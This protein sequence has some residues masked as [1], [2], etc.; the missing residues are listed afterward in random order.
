MSE[1][2]IEA[3]APEKELTDAEK[4]GFKKLPTDTDETVIK[5]TPKESLDIRQKA[6]GLQPKSV[7]KVVEKFTP[8]IIPGVMDKVDRKVFVDQ[9]KVAPYIDVRSVLNPTDNTE[10]KEAIMSLKGYK[11]ESP[12]APKGTYLPFVAKDYDGR[13]AEM[14]KGQA[15]HLIDSQDQ[16]EP[17][18]F[19]IGLAQYLKAPKDYEPLTVFGIPVAQKIQELTGFPLDEVGGKLVYIN[20]LNKKLK[21]LGVSTRSRYGIIKYRLQKEPGAF[22]SK[23]LE[24]AFNDYANARGYIRNGVR[25]VIEA[26]L[27]IAGEVFDAVNQEYDKTNLSPIGEGFEIEDP[28]GET[29]IE[30]SEGR[31]EL[32]EDFLPAQSSVIQDHFAALGIVVDLPTSQALASDFSNLPTR[33]FGVAGEMLIPASYLT[34]VEK[35][36]GKAEIANFRHFSVKEKRLNPKIT[37][38]DIL[39]KYQTMRS[40]QVAGFDLVSPVFELPFVGGVGKKINGYINAG[41]LASGMD[42]RQAGMAMR[43][44]NPAIL[45]NSKRI[46]QQKQDIISFKASRPDMS[47]QDTKKLELME[48]DLEKE[49]IDHRALVHREHIPKFIRDIAGQNK[50]MIIGA[51]AGGQLAENT[52]SDAKIF[53]LVGL[54]T[55]LVYGQ[56]RTFRGTM[57][58]FKQNIRMGRADG[59]TDRAKTFDLAEQMARNIN[60]FSPEFRDALLSR[61]RY[62]GD[63][64]QRLIRAGVSEDL[65][66]RS[67]SRITGLT[68]LQTLEEAERLNINTKDLRTFSNLQN[69]QELSKEKEALIAE[70]RSASI[71]VSNLPAGTQSE[72][73]VEEFYN[74][75][76]TAT[77]MAD[78]R[79]KKLQAD[80]ETVEKLLPIRVNAMIKENNGTYLAGSGDEKLQ[81]KDALEYLY[82]NGVKEV[83]LE[84]VANSTKK[85]MDTSDTV[86]TAVNTAIKKIN[87]EYN[88]QDALA[89]TKKV[90]TG[91][92]K[93]VKIVGEQKGIPTFK[94]AG[95]LTAV[96]L[97]NSKNRSYNLARANYK[98][99][100]KAEFVTKN[101]LP[102]GR[103][104]KT[105][106]NE[107][108]SSLFENMD[109]ID[110]Q[111]FGDKGIGRSKRARLLN[112]L[113]GIGDS[114]F[115]RIQQGTGAES[116]SEVVE[117]VLA[118]ARNDK[119]FTFKKGL[120]EKMQA[121]QYISETK[122]VS[123]IDVNFDQL[124]ELKHSVNRL[125]YKAKNSGDATREA[126][127]AG[128]MRNVKERFDFFRTEDGKSIGQLYIKDGDRRVP[129]KAFLAEGDAKYSDHM[130]RYYGNDVIAGWLGLGKKDGRKNRVPNQDFPVGVKY[131]KNPVTWLDMDQIANMDRATKG[132]DFNQKI[133][134]GFGTFNEKLGV[135]RIDIS[136]EDGKA[137]QKAFELKGAEWLIGEYRKGNLNYNELKDKID[138]IQA[139]LKGVDANGKEVS[140]INLNKIIDDKLGYAPSNI[141]K[142]IYTEGE[143]IADRFVEKQV[144]VVKVQSKDVQKGITA[145]T[146]IIKTFTAN[147]IDS[148]SILEGL[149][150]GGTMRL[151]S[152]KNSLIKNGIAKEKVDEVLENLLLTQLDNTVFEKTGRMSLIGGAKNAKM[153]PEYNMNV[154]Q[155][156]DLVGFSDPTKADAVKGI[157]GESKYQFYTDMI[158]FL[159]NESIRTIK[160]ANFTGVPKNLSIESYISRFYS[161]NRGVISARYVGTEA[162]LQQFRLK[163]HSM[164]KALLLD[165]EAGD[166]F[167][168]MVKSGKPLELNDE[169]RFFNLMGT[170][171]AKAI[172]TNEEQASKVTIDL[173]NSHQ[174]GITEYQ[175]ARDPRIQSAYEGIRDPLKE[176]L[177]EKQFLFDEQGRQIVDGR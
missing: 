120:S 113:E 68:V 106:A 23:V 96:L 104:A 172:N 56:T 123:T 78:G 90:V 121:L 168:K 43:G 69:L 62:F 157:I 124:N 64:Q 70:L 29:L 34:K 125:L 73:V 160:N 136:T 161:I 103:N 105:S 26:P 48:A 2:Q 122:N 114:T 171:L 130:D 31:D 134:Q 51:A 87:G 4:L 138:N 20:R 147:N 140:L 126:A 129:V 46:E 6:S 175:L 81:L 19:E 174:F 145:A 59:A 39:D 12:N 72:K 163:N 98:I 25:S 150:G 22:D 146:N 82:D 75:V 154:D 55:G 97:E 36:Y 100:D 58:W 11:S 132:L 142:E 91:V 148:K 52:D 40:K 166:L 162:V 45:E 15:T 119:N 77:D 38:D 35:L 13:I 149:L 76:K 111:D 60:T 16:A 117:S 139:N 21:D 79:L 102:A 14:N 54:A 27:F 28:L 85:I 74:I 1:P 167:L 93:R 110:I 3:I 86:S 32:L 17:I 107:I 30:S 153:I 137:V 92:D 61:I 108:V 155:L 169:K 151:N 101:G 109:V 88:L 94:R 164:F 71:S 152:I 24:P 118:M 156:K 44:R 176:R 8:S 33:G 5:T 131:A 158:G 50:Y 165:R 18:P 159:E 99:L 83:D 89:Q 41:R 10:I 173:G 80:T 7:E 133:N 37:P 84:N 66:K 177:Q 143:A 9:R 141:K 112:A 63:M 47:Y 95:N 170:A 144:S 115:Q 67:F 57:N 128:L 116:I 42:I 135:H 53:E 127:F 49:I 65:V